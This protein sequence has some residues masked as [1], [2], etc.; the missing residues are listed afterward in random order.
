M[1]V[2]QQLARLTVAELSDCRRSVATLHELC[3]FN[4][5]DACD[6]LDLNWS[7]VPLRRAAALAELPHE[8]LA[9]VQRSCRGD[10]EI[11][12]AYRDHPRTIWEHPVNAIEPDAVESIAALLQRWTPADIV[13][14]VPDDRTLA[15]QAL[16]Y[17]EMPERPRTY[18]SEHFELLR[19]FYAEAADR[20][21]AMAM[22]WDSSTNATAPTGSLEECTSST[23]ARRL[24]NVLGRAHR[25]ALRDDRGEHAPLAHV[26]PSLGR[27]RAPPG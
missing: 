14:A 23:K 10:T 26:E 16:P 19:R 17:G 12:P 4:L 13:R 9:A 3:S 2:T 5:R 20:H 25:H 22:W 27:I 21:L 1:A 24:T 15:E 18:L 8:L 6:Y 7:P 11:N